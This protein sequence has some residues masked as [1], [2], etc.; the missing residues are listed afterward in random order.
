M[1]A[2]IKENLGVISSSKRVC[3][4]FS[5]ELLSRFFFLSNFPLLP[6]IDSFKL[7]NQ[8]SLTL[9]ESKNDREEEFNWFNLIKLLSI[10]STTTNNLNLNSFSDKT[11]LTLR[12]KNSDL[13]LHSLLS[14]LLPSNLLPRL[15]ST[16]TSTTTKNQQPTPTEIKSFRSELGKLVEK[17]LKQEKES[18]SEFSKEAGGWRRSL[19]DESKGEKWESIIFLLCVMALRKIVGDMKI[20]ESNQIVTGKE[21]SELYRSE[22][23]KLSKLVEERESTLAALRLKGFE[24]LQANQE[25]SAFLNSGDTETKNDYSELDLAH[26]TALRDQKVRNY[27]SDLW[28]VRGSTVAANGSLP[29]VSIFTFFRGN[30]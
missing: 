22:V 9:T 21:G 13:I 20:D 4:L 7:L 29:K 15:I 25:H 26:L 28:S 11:P 12:L 19:L 6:L 3:L 27:S 16:S 5:F 24:L 1:V 23:E 30:Y 14:I 18:N 17:L 2:T 8:L 10:H